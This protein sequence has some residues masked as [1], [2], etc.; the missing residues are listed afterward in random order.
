MAQRIQGF[1]PPC[2]AVTSFAFQALPAGLLLRC[3]GEVPGCPARDCWQGIARSPQADGCGWHSFSLLRHTRNAVVVSERSGDHLVVD[4]SPGVRISS[5]LSSLSDLHRI[6]K[7]MEIIIIRR[8]LV[9]ATWHMAKVLKHVA[10]LGL[11]TG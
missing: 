2:F 8:K 6:I 11:C 1:F 7:T 10:A 9:G 4:A 3:S 5:Q